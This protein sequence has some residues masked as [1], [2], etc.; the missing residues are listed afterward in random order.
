MTDRDGSDQQT[1]PLPVD[2][3]ASIPHVVNGMVRS[4][5]RPAEQVLCDG[6]SIAAD[7]RRILGT[8]ALGTKNRTASIKTTDCCCTPCRSRIDTL[9]ELIDNVMQVAIAIEESTDH[10]IRSGDSQ[11]CDSVPSTPQLPRQHRWRLPIDSETDG[12]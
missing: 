7:L 6:L 2:S 10:R 9:D 12:E 8:L 11:N 1:E 4:S 3:R 5:V